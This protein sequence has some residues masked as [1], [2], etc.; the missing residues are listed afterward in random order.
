MSIRTMLLPIILFIFMQSLSFGFSYR[1]VV[2]PFKGFVWQGARISQAEL[3]NVTIT[4]ETPYIL[5]FTYQGK[6]YKATLFTFGA[7]YLE[8][9]DQL[10]LL[11]TFDVK[12]Y[13]LDAKFLF[14][15]EYD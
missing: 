2:F 9:Q 8:R 15:H 11:I 6:K 1:E 4:K 5:E 10:P 14:I 3:P 7:I 12:E 13:K